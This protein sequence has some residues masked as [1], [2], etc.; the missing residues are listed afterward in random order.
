MLVREGPKSAECGQD[1]AGIPN[2]SCRQAG[3]ENTGG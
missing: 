3:S 2:D 1:V